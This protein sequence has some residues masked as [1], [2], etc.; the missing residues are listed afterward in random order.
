[1]TPTAV[2]AL[3]RE[4]E[5]R[6]VDLRFMDFPGLWQHFTI[7]AEELD[8]QTFEEGKGFDGS[9]IR[10]WVAINESDML[11]KPAPE[12]AIFGP[13]RPKAT[14]SRPIDFLRGGRYTTTAIPSS[15][16]NEAATEIA[17]CRSAR[18]R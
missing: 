9:S 18:K 2:L 11:V 6:A 5:V 10:G 13:A 4:K 8:E 14:T 1:M 16:V 17:P 15:P 12:T 7:P 3:V